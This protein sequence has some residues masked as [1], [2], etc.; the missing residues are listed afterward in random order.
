MLCMQLGVIAVEPLFSSRLATVTT[1]SI[2]GG[3]HGRGNPVGI[4]GGLHYT[5]TDLYYFGASCHPT[6]SNKPAKSAY[7]HW[8]EQTHCPKEGTAG[9]R[10]M[11]GR[12]NRG[13]DH[14]TCIFPRGG[15]TPPVGAGPAKLT[16]P[17]GSLP[18][19]D[20]I[21]S[22]TVD[23]V[24]ELD[25]PTVLQCAFITVF[26][27]PG[28]MFASGHIPPELTAHRATLIKMS[29]TPAMALPLLFLHHRPLQITAKWTLGPWATLSGFSRRRRLLPHLRSADTRMWSS[30]RQSL[31]S[32]RPPWELGGGGAAE[33]TG[34]PFPFAD[35]R[36]D[37][38]PAKYS[39]F[40]DVKGLDLQAFG[41]QAQ[42]VGSPSPTVGVRQ[43]PTRP[44]TTGALGSTSSWNEPST[45]Y[46]GD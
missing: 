38:G 37:S 28:D 42:R 10:T 17:R 35:M 18:P 22:A 46:D 2:F 4:D 19:G 43:R 5:G 1:P 26:A 8:Y 21:G 23:T 27:V 20:M 6:L 16:T 15:G 25:V 11:S 29:F 31:T 12:E 40:A 45:N 30:Q 13:W 32:S 39:S 33:D 9:H 34:K 36:S 24:V 3:L 14:T 7:A 44:P 41:Q